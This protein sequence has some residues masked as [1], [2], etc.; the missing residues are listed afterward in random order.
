MA[1]TC[2]NSES[3]QN[4]L[5]SEATIFDHESRFQATGHLSFLPF[6]LSHANAEREGMLDDISATHACDSYCGQS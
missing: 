6:S 5:Q 4:W 1:K 3:T 2:S